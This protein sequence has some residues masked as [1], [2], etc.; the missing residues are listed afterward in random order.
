[1][2]ISNNKY[3]FKLKYKEKKEHLKIKILCLKFRL[4]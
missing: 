4:N 2:I 3:Y 1:M